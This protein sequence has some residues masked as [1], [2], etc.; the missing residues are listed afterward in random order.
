MTSDSETAQLPLIVPLGDAGLLVRFAT[1]LSDAANRR[2]VAFARGLTATRLPRGVAEIMPNLVSVLLKYDPRQIGF[3]EL[4]GE[5]RL[6]IGTA[7]EEV[8]GAAHSIA[9]RFDGEDLDEVAAALKIAP[10][11]FVAGH[12]ERPL[13]VLATGFAPG[14]VYCGFHPAELALPRRATVRPL[15]PPGTVLFAAGQT[16]IAATPIPTG[17][18]VIG[19]TDFRNFEP[20][21]EPPT[22]LRAGDQV[23]FEALP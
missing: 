17:W 23:Q 9:V 5:V 21:A 20:A 13:R 3:D 14:F 7:G 8:A 15:V 6:L 12:N 1:T 2:A 22:T 4:A 18:H 16:A 19:H 11:A 10:D